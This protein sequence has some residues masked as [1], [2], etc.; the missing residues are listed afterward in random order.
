MSKKTAR[1]LP[2]RGKRGNTTEI[3]TIEIVKAIEGMRDKMK[4]GFKYNNEE[5]IKIKKGMRGIQEDMGRKKLAWDKE[6]KRISPKNRN[7]GKCHGK[8]GNGKNKKQHSDKGNG[9]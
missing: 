8:T 1:S 6:K 2:A 3:R 9:N 4:T 5:L 7:Y